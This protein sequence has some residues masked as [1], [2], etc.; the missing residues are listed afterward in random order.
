MYIGHAFMLR[1]QAAGGKYTAASY[2]IGRMTSLSISRLL[3]R[4][5]PT[6]RPSRRWE[7]Y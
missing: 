7:G 4:C 6:L 1:D 5:N 2:D 3:Q